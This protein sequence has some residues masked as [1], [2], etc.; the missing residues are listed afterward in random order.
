MGACLEIHCGR[1]CRRWRPARWIA[2]SAGLE[3]VVFLPSK[4]T[5]P[6]ASPSIRREPPHAGAGGARSRP[7]SHILAM[8]ERG[9]GPE[10]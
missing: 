5:S 8:L 4:C 3:P 6:V 9:S 1:W 7:M 10:R 2:G